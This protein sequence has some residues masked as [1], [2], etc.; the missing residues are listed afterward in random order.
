M[1]IAK[2]EGISLFDYFVS[3]IEVVAFDSR[4]TNVVSFLISTF[5]KTDDVDS[6]MALWRKHF[7]NELIHLTQ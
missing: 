3:G 6:I 1:R 4:R 7:P 5:A 2:G